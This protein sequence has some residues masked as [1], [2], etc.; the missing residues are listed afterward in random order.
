MFVKSLTTFTGEI[1]TDYPL[2]SIKENN[3]YIL[4]IYPQYH[5]VMSPDSISRNENVNVLEDVSYTDYPAA[6]GDTV[7]LSRNS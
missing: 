4:S 1:L 5:F 2:I 7:E 3:K 6:F